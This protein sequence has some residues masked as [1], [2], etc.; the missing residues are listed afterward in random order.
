MLLS[1]SNSAKVYL[2][3]LWEGKKPSKES[4]ERAIKELS[5][6]AEADEI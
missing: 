4:V 3:W 6:E 5:S 1:V 2:S